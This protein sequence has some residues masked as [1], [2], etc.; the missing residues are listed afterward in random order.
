MRHPGGFRRSGWRR[1]WVLFGGTLLVAVVLATASGAVSSSARAF[2]DIPTMAG[3][4]PINGVPSV[5]G[6]GNPH[7]SVSLAALQAAAPGTVVTA[8]SV[9]SDGIMRGYLLISPARPRPGLPLIVVL[10]GVN[11]SPT[12]EAE[13]DE[14]LPVVESGDAILVYPA[15]YGESWNVGV[16]DCCSTAAFVGVNDVGFVQI[17]TDTVRASTAA[18]ATYLVGFSNGGKLAYQVLCQHPGLFTAAA[19]VG[20]TPLTSCPSEVALPMLIAVGAK[21]PELPEQ[22]HTQNPV[23]VFTAALATWRAYNGCDADSTVVG[24]GTA[25]TTTWSACSSGA[26]VVGVLYLGL[27]HGWPTARL[28]GA[29][30]AGAPKIWAFLSGASASAELAGQ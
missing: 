20:A 9:R 30:V 1:V 3:A 12:Q 4:K 25:V 15:G 17:V 7:G 14:L 18:S 24:V 6:A 26:D 2:V 23:K 27:D 16:G 21:D 28:V 8:S 19:I 10:G 29:N 5:T 13:R 22:G 11:A